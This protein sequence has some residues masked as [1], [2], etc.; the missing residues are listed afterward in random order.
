MAEPPAVPDPSWPLDAMRARSPARIFAG[1]A[2]LGYRTA[3]A[4]R[5]REDHA[6]AVDA[7]RVEMD[8][9]RDFGAEFV[10]L[11]GLFEVATC[12][13]SKAE[14]LVRPDLGRRLSGAAR[15]AIA[16][17]CPR[18]ADLQV[19]IGDG[20]SATAVMRQ[21]PALLPG[22]AEEC[23]SRGW[24]VGRPVAIRYCRV[25][26]LNDL[27]ECLDPAVAVLLIGERPGLA[28]AESLSAY[29]AYRPQPGRTDADRSLISNIHAQGIPAA[30]AARRI[31]DLA[32]LM[33]AQRTSGV[34]LDTDAPFNPLAARPEANANDGRESPPV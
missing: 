28:T 16:G 21:V 18:D 15:E 3:T 2:G 34:G 9:V 13:R 25:G 22:L 10:D 24:S 6:F 26:V 1:R 29:V 27:G 7:V 19:A 14:Y 32:A 20:L 30:E 4:L 33:L 23:R 12:A 8:L 31:A 17:R 11:W 5:L